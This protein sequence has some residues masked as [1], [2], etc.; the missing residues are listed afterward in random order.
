MYG[1]GSGSQF[2]P[3]DKDGHASMWNKK[4]IFWELP[5]WEIPEVHNTIDVMHV[6]KNFCLNLLGV[7]TRPGKYDTI[8]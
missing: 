7:T 3:K 4:S 6:M 5:Y 2:V 1:K 8:A